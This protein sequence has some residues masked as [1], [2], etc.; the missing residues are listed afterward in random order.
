MKVLFLEFDTQREWAVTSIGPS[1]IA[2]Y[3]RESGHE[4]E[5][6]RISPDQSLRSI[7]QSVKEKQPGLLATSLTSRQWIRSRDVV[8]ALREKLDVPVI[9]GGLHPTFCPEAVLEAGFDFVCLGEGETATLDLIEALETGGPSADQTIPNIWVRGGERPPLRPPVESLDA[10]PFM[11]R[12]M[13]DEQNGVVH[14]VTQRGCPLPCTYCAAR[15][16]FDL[17]KGADYGK[18]RSHEN[19]LD[20]LHQIRAESQ[21]NYVIFLDDTFTLSPK[22]VMEFCRRYERE[23]G[24]GFSIHAR[25]DTVDEEMLEALADAG[26]KHIVYGVESGSFRVRRDIMKR[27]IPDETFIEVFEQ[28]RH[29]GIIV[30]ANYMLGLPGETRED[31]DQTLSLHQKLRPHDFGYFVFYPYPGTHLFQ[32]CRDKG[33]LP[34]NY[35]DLP[36]IHKQSILNLPDLSQEDILWYYDEFTRLREENYLEQ[37]GAALDENQKPHLRESIAESAEMG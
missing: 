28:T 10:M 25:V 30:T 19:V 21:L 4:A 29:L 3:I 11:A 15:N 34:E 35:L 2:S 9:A 12:D 20:E 8:R 13:L 27:P 22:W 7:V 33:Y 17:Y 5:L 14:V 6:L 23:L 36:A 31:I 26:C 16:L 18:R 32:V 1:L 24:I 37:F